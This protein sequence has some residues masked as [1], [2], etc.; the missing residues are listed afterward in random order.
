[1]RS[2]LAI[3]SVTWL[4]TAQTPPA[5][6]DGQYAGGIFSIPLSDVPKYAAKTKM[7]RA[8]E[9]KSGG[10]KTSGSGP[11]PA[12][13]AMD[14]SI[15]NHT[16]YAPIAKPNITMPII[17]WDNG[18]CGTDPTQ[19]GNFLTE[20]ASHGYVISAVG[21]AG[22]LGRQSKVQDNRDSIEWA[23]KGSAAKYGEVD[24]T[25]LIA[26]GQSCGGL[27]AYS[28]SY[29][30]PRVK[31]LM[32]FNVGI[33]DDAKRYLIKEIKTPIGYFL[34]GVTDFGAPGAEKDYV[35]LPAGVPAWKGN[36]DTGHGGTYSATNGGK[37]GIAAVDFLQW[38]MRGDANSKAKMLDP[39]TAGSLVSQN[40]K[41]E[42]KNW[43]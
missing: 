16:V 34:G 2:L 20:V 29:H 1:M 8:T 10:A 40:W 35:E 12:K 41:V 43:T 25:K 38:Q 7:G 42:F 39:K 33:F 32:L 30:D 11:Y 31:L 23:L 5:K 18:G 6:S 14:T 15:P 9:A 17:V 36:L 37:M 24:T 27:S 26:A 3:L 21:K 19:F 22:G 13:G 28:T 4:A